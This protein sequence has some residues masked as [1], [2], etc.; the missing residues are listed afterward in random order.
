MMEV[1]LKA[2]SKITLPGVIESLK[3]SPGPPGSFPK[4]ATEHTDDISIALD[5]FLVVG[6]V[7]TK[8]Y[9]FIKGKKKD[10]IIVFVRKDVVMNFD[11]WQSSTSYF[12]R[13]IMI[14][15]NLRLLFGFAVVGKYG[16]KA[17]QCNRNL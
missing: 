4:K 3:R 12:S 13:D 10:E 9:I 6:V 5:M 11:N 16:I 1:I 15:T 17:L 14:A 7:S 8:D 2:G